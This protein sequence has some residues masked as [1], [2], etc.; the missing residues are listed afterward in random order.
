M[1]AGGT[2]GRSE[3]Q[4]RN[5]GA[6]PSDSESTP[7]TLESQSGL[8]SW[9]WNKTAITVRWLSANGIVLFAQNKQSSSV[10]CP[11]TVDFMA[12]YRVTNFSTSTNKLQSAFQTQS[13][14]SNDLIRIS[15]LADCILVSPGGSGLKPIKWAWVKMQLSGDKTPVWLSYKVLSFDI[16]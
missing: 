3:I 10:G 9:W 6:V 7:P 15:W 16:V 12:P 14:Y 1:F 4:D 13:L 8:I 2:A 11:Y 5:S